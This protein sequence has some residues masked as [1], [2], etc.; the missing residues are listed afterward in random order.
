MKRLSQEAVQTMIRERGLKMTPQRQAIVE[1]LQNAV[2]HPTAEEI[3]ESVN[4]R[5]PMTSRA[6]IYN[7]LNWLKDAGQIAE[8]HEGGVAR[9]DPNL[10]PHHHFVCRVCG[11]VEDLDWE[12]VGP[13]PQC[14]LRGKQTVETYDITL[15]G[16]CDKCA[17]K[18]AVSV[19]L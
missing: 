3:F 7:T 13:L 1:Y 9:F 14:V 8:V 16:V 18:D 2:H 4:R 17:R 11:G 12:A 19:I 15:R 10:E 5:F 6:T